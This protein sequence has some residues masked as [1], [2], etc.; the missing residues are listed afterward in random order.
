[1]RADVHLDVPS[2]TIAHNSR[3]VITWSMRHVF[4]VKRCAYLTIRSGR[5][6]PTTMKPA[7]AASKTVQS[8]IA[9]P[10][11]LM[12]S[13]VYNRSGCSARAT[14]NGASTAWGETSPGNAAGTGK[15]RPARTGPSSRQS[16][17]A[18]S[19]SSGGGAP[20]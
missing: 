13:T 14:R 1:M 9:R 10:V 18:R 2:A 17:V 6:A 7:A 5:T 16:G 15:T 19:A 8:K 11:R 4:A 12:S 20:G 3:N